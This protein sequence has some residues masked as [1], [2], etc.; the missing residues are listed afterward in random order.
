MAFEFTQSQQIV[1]FQKKFERKTKK[2]GFVKQM[3]CKAQ[4]LGVCCLW[5]IKTTMAS[6]S[7]NNN[8]LG[9]DLEEEFDLN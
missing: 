1:V 5:P 8:G 4:Q 6:A 9:F 7:Q 3:P 2:S